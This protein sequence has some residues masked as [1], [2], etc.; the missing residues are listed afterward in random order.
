[1]PAAERVWYVNRKRKESRTKTRR[2]VFKKRNEKREE[3]RCKK[4]QHRA[5]PRGPPPQYYPGSN[6]NGRTGE[7]AENIEI[8]ARALCYATP[9]WEPPLSLLRFGVPGLGSPISPQKCPPVPTI[10]SVDPVLVTW[11]T[12]GLARCGGYNYHKPQGSSDTE[13][14]HTGTGNARVDLP[15]LTF[16][17]SR[18][19]VGAQPCCGAG[20]ESVCH[21]ALAQPRLRG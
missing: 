1:M 10:I 14:M 18:H 4:A 17:A 13:V 7:Q 12:P 2:E 16:T 11:L 8:S 15:S 9:C 5:F 6:L 20:S 21:G 19:T 3:N